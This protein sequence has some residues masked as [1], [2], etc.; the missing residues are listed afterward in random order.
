[1]EETLKLLENL[2]ELVVLIE[3]GEF[4]E[5]MANSIL[6]TLVDN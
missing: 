5:E 3:N 1:M 4:T 2:D 6:K